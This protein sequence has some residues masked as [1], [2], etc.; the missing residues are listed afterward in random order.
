MTSMQGTQTRIT[1]EDIT[2]LTRKPVVHAWNLRLGLA[3]Q[4]DQ[5]FKANLG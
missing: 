1:H 5:E 2:G 4:K 3:R